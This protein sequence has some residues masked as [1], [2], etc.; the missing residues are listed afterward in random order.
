MEFTRRNF[1]K[2]MTIAGVGVALFGAAG[3][4]PTQGNGGSSFTAGTYT[5]EKPGKFAPIKVETSFSEDAITEVKVVSHEES[6]FVSDR[7]INDIPAMIVENQTLDIDA[8][9]G[10]TLTSAAILSAVEDC[11]KQAGGNPKKLSDYEKP[12]PSTEVVDLEADLVIAGG[13]G[14]GMA[15]AIA[16]AQ[17]GAEKVVVIEKNSNFGGNALVSAG[18]VEYID[19]PDEMKSPTTPDLERTIE[20]VISK[21]P[22]I[23]PAEDLEKIEND[24]EAWRE[25]N[26]GLCFDS[27]EFQSL[28]Y[29]VDEG[30]EYSSSY[31]FCRNVREFANWISELGLEFTDLCSIVGYPWPRWTCPKEGSLGNGYFIFYDKLMKEEGYPIEIHLCTTATELITDGNNVVGLKAVADDGTT[32]NVTS[33]KGVVLATGGFAGN[34]DML[35]EYNTIWPFEEGK[36]IPTTNTN[37]HTGD[38]IRMA[39]TLGAQTDL[40]D[41]QMPFPMADCKNSTDETTVGDD[42]D[43]I[44]VNKDGVRFMDEIQDRYTMTKHI[45]EQ[46]DEMMYMITDAD[47]CLVKGEV[48]RYDRNLQNLINQGQLFVADTIEELAE[49]M[50]CDPK[51]LADSIARYNEFAKNGKD[52]DFGRTWFSDHSVIENPPF[53]ASPRTWAMHITEGG[54]VFDE[55]FRVIGEND[56]PIPGLYS[57]G[58]INAYSSGIGTQGEGLMLSRILFA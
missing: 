51:A 50:G 13:G 32:Y 37:G 2:T 15:C 58:E 57:I 14:S 11:V 24:L 10:A 8:F 7:A 40:M 9:T 5:S 56:E 12:A 55:N 53:Y 6:P 49:K 39:Q 17:L 29:A 23:A 54:L 16:A 31:P 38:G 28:Q 18:Y 46:P 1:V 35:R 21:G 26:S 19:A 34:P 52:E 47:T 3:C 41:L 33:K 44:I 48:S 36:D 27:L 22:D 4:S 43:C 25:A 30:S 42:M 45:M 20:D